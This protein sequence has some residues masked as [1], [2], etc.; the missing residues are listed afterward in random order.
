M[1]VRPLVRL[2]NP[3][4]RQRA[5]EIEASE[6]STPEFQALIDDMIETMHQNNGAG[7]AAPQ[8][9][10]SLR[11]AVAEVEKNAR[12]PEMGPIPLSVWIN[13]VI[14]VLSDDVRV[15]MYEGCLSV[16]GLRGRVERPA[17]IR[18]DSLNRK[19]ER[20]VAV[21]RGAEAAVI[22][23]ELDHLD[24]V[25]FVDRADSKTLTYLEEYERFV[26]KSERLNV[27]D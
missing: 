13:P 23:H 27:L 4:L 11:L 22:Q 20:E 2:G 3:V 26:D 8:I 1:A 9:G 7:L 18:L 5:R 12:Y 24:G 19:G 16:P 17:H 6:I 25:L 14:T 10:V 21:I 15:A